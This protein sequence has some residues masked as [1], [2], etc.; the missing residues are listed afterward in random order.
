MV[1]FDLLFR[2][3]IDSLFFYPRLDLHTNLALVP[4]IDYEDLLGAHLVW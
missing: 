4:L 3:E 1:S 2:F